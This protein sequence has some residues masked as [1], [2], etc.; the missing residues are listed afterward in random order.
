MR[1]KKAKQ[2]RKKLQWYKIHHEL[3]PPYKILVDGNFFKPCVD[4]QFDLKYKVEK[5]SGGKVWVSTTSC[6]INELNQLGEDFRELLNAARRLKKEKC[7]HKGGPIEPSNCIKQ[8]I[9][10]KNVLIKNSMRNM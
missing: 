4:R 7:V 5:L 2:F 3:H 1:I 10:I 6:V 9:G 8:I